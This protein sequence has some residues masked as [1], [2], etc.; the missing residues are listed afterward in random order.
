MKL[1]KTTDV[2]KNVVELEISVPAEEFNAAVNAVY[3]KK[4]AQINVPGFRKGKA[5]RK[6]IEKM[7]GESIFWDDAVSALYPTAYEDAVREAKIQPVDRADVEVTSVSVADGFTFKAKVTVKP[8]VSVNEYKGLTVAKKSTAVTEEEV[9]TELKGYQT[10]N[11]RMLDID[12]RETQNG[13][14]V[15]FDF[16]GFI[17]GKPFDGGKAEGYTLK[18][19]SGQFIPGFEEQM[20]GKKIDEEFSV[21]VTFPEEYHAKEL[22]GQPAEFKIKLHNIKVEELP[23]I[24][25]DFIKDIS[26]FDTVDAFRED[27]KKKVAERKERDADADLNDK[28]SQA[29]AD[30]VI[31]DIPACMFENEIN[32]NLQGF[33]NRMASQGISLQQYLEITGSN[34]EDMRNMFKERADRD[35]KLRLALEKIAELEG[36]IIEDSEVDAEYEKFSKEMKTPVE[37]IKNDAVTEKIIKELSIDKAFECVKNN[38]IITEE[39]VVE[40][41]KAPAR[42]PRKKKTSEKQNE[43]QE[44]ATEEKATE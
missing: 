10:R 12:D 20:V 14:T 42:K 33:E 15:V 34:M 41:K 27:L 31:A 13:D 29:V 16:E 21:N 25:D 37:R 6:I 43:Q 32:A 38:A 40:P 28:L 23:E 36:I 17:D 11:A 8:E 18:L 30:L 26:D 4:A 44:V 2:E 9:D 3:T 22:K 7:Y 19:G 5:P 1:V 39:T 35:V 24:N